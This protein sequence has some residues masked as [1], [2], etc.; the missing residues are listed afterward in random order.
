MTREDVLAILEAGDFDALLGTPEALE[1]EYKGQPY[2]LDTEGQKFELAKDV[3]AFANAAGG[4]LV[5]G[6]RTETDDQSAVDVAAEVRPFARALVDV[7]HYQDTLSARIY[8]SMRDIN[9]RFHP[10]AAD[11]N[12]GVIAIDVPLQQEIDR[13]FLVQRPIIEGADRTPGWLVGIAVRG[14]G[15]VELREIGELHTLINRGVNVGRTLGDLVEMVA[16]IREGG[17]AEAAPVTAPADRLAD[18]IERRL[19]EIGE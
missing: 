18:V 7:Q 9:V 5:I 1:I 16:E 6:I 17:V 10:M 19:G 11:P 3:S 12:R 13:Y 8:P 14:I 15:R 2:Q 4:V